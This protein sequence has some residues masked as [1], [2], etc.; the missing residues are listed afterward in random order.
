MY[1]VIRRQIPWSPTCTTKQCK[2][3]PTHT[4]R[5]QPTSSV[6]RSNKNP[7]N[8]TFTLFIKENKTTVHFTNVRLFLP[9][10]QPVRPCSG[11]NMTQ[12]AQQC[13]K[14]WKELQIASCC[15]TFNKVYSV[16]VQLRV[17]ERHLSWDQ[18]LPGSGWLK[19]TPLQ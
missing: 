9:V 8:Q 18:V 6:P 3:P 5:V 15:Y 11:S 2:T 4:H 19:W 12:V 10:T 17:H 16:Y 13:G 14:Q 7:A 1:P